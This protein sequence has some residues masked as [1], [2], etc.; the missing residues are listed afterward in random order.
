MDEMKAIALIKSML[1]KPIKEM[2]SEIENIKEGG[3][4]GTGLPVGAAPYQQLVTD[5]NGAV[6]WEDR[7]HYKEEAQLFS[8]EVT[9]VGGMGR[10]IPIYYVDGETYKVLFNGTEYSVVAH[11]VMGTALI[12]NEGIALGN[13]PVDGEIPFAC[14]NG[15]IAVRVDGAYSITIY[16]PQ[17]HTIQHQY[18]PKCVVY[19]NDTKDQVYSGEHRYVMYEDEECA[20]VV[21]G[22]DYELWNNMINGL[23]CVIYDVN[24]NSYHY[25][26]CIYRVNGT[27]CMI[28]IRDDGDDKIYQCH[29]MS[30]S[31]EEN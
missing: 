9:V 28:Y 26:N 25:P 24:R 18:I 13:D 21:T 14:V 8:G 17:F 11:K 23:G 2:K 7:T 5:E 4:G 6:K 1:N 10:M 31:D 15:V 12:G 22:N 20:R 19:T 29:L 30:C 16:G 3:A 27:I